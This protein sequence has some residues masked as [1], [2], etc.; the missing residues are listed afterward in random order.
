MKVFLL[1]SSHRRNC[2]CDA[3]FR[4]P[5]PLSTSSQTDMDTTPKAAAILKAAQ[6]KDLSRQTR[7]FIWRLLHDA[8]RVGRWWNNI[9][10]CGDRALYQEC[11]IEE[12]M[13][14]ILF[15][16]DAPGRQIIWEM[17]IKLLKDKTG[18]EPLLTIGTL[19]AC[20]MMPVYDENHKPRPASSRLKRILIAEAARTIWKITCD[21]VIDNDPNF[22]RK[23]T[24]K[25][26]MSRWMLAIN[27]RQT[28]TTSKNLTSC[29]HGQGYSNAKTSCRRT[30]LNGQ[31]L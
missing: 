25:E 27:K 18:E 30:G 26:M 2:S 14:H 20:C 22:G 23:H 15:R 12:S 29:V 8:F 17:T 9:P 6:H 21:R 16:C 5:P 7:Y 24:I 28:P 1:E 13:E 3:R 31:G 10:E 4:A 11:R 19:M